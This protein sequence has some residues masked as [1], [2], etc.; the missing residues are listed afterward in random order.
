MDCSYCY[1]RS[2]CISFFT[3]N[4]VLGRHIYAVG[5]NPE[6]AELCISVQKITTFVFAS[7]GTLA[8]LAGILFTARLQSATITAEMHLKWMLLHHVM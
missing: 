4:T 6:A 2:C 3:N 8:G 1:K 7:M 5:G